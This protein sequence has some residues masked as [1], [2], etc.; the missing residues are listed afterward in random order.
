[1][2]EGA[3]VVAFDNL[4]NGRLS[5][6]ER[7]R[8][9][10]HFK[11]IKGD[12]CEKAQ[13]RRAIGGASVVFHLAGASDV[14]PRTP[15]HVY[16]QNNIVATQNLLDAMRSSASAKGIVFASSSTV[17]GRAK[18]IPTPE[19]YGPME[20]ISMY[21]ASKLA[22]EAL[23]SAYSHLFG[24]SAAVLRLAN[25]VGSRSNH[26]VGY[27]FTR[28]LM[29]SPRELHVKGDGNQRKS[30]LYVDDLISA[31]KITT[32]R[33]S[34]GVDFFNVGSEDHIRVKAIAGIVADQLR[35]DRPILRFG[36]AFQGGGWPGDVPE[37]LLSV[38]KIRGLGWR[39]RSNSAE[40]V[41]HATNALIAEFKVARTRRWGEG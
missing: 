20:P 33:L 34:P 10:E 9:H 17:Y 16:L 22:C 23:I 13:I 4:S 6:L 14:D 3:T 31:I 8:G 11:F 7:W 32:R 28:K 18:I 19:D 1:M 37:M 30:Y 15:P 38:E 36:R 2:A 27:D 21:G 40:A 5:N 24:F 39:P 12:L 35:I 26:G 41:L 29:K 25:I